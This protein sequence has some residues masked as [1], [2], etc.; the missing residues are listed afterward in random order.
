M[1]FGFLVLSI[2]L[3]PAR[4][5]QPNP[6]RHPLE[7]SAL[8]LANVR[9][10]TPQPQLRQASPAVLQGSRASNLVSGSGPMGF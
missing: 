7:F 4:I 9:R 8:R 6:Q 2:R 3:A 10:Q 1:L 5:L